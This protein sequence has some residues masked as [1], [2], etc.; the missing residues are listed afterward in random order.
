[1]HVNQFAQPVEHA[2]MSGSKHVHH[3]ARAMVDVFA[4]AHLA[5]LT[6]CAN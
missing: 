4:A 6:G 3:R 1:M 5:M 2:E